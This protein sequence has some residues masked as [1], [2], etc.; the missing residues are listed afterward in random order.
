MRGADGNLRGRQ[1]ALHSRT[2]RAVACGFGF[3]GGRR[4]PPTAFPGSR[5]RG[6]RKSGCSFPKFAGR[7]RPRRR[8]PLPAQAFRNRAKE[9]PTP[10]TLTEASAPR[11]AAS[12]SFHHKPRRQ[13][14]TSLTGNSERQN[15]ERVPPNC[16][17]SHALTAKVRT[18]TPRALPE[19]KNSHLRLS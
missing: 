2:G 4:G 7:A 12:F 15:P 8:A 9:S 1:P 6:P 14:A 18:V 10:K 19:L 11:A 16:G 3:S 17:S 13:T 5:T